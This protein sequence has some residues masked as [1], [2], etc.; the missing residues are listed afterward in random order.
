MGTEKNSSKETRKR[1]RDLGKGKYIV[2]HV[3]F[4]S[5]LDA[6]MNEILHETMLTT[7]SA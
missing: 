7:S 6:G 5:L 1:A 4:Y 2:S 3:S